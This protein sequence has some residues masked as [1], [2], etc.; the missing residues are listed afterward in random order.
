MAPAADAEGDASKGGAVEEPQLAGEQEASLASRVLFSWVSPLVARGHRRKLQLDELFE[1]T[2]EQIAWPAPKRLQPPT[3]PSALAPP[4][5]LRCMRGCFTRR[6]V[7][8]C[9]RRVAACCIV[10]RSW[11]PRCFCDTWSCRWLSRRV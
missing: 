4:P 3:R 6:D 11:R 9:K 2:A 1:L 7:T 5:R 10:P 8:C